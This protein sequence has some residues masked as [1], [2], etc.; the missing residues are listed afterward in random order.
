MSSGL[1]KYDRGFVLLRVLKKEKRKKKSNTSI[2]LHAILLLPLIV[3]PLQAAEQPEKLPQNDRSQQPPSL[4]RGQ[5]TTIGAWVP[6]F[7]QKFYL[8]IIMP[9]EKKNCFQDVPRAHGAEAHLAS[10]GAPGSG[11]DVALSCSVLVISAKNL[12][13]NLPSWPTLK[14]PTSII[15]SALI[16]TPL[17]YPKQ[18]FQQESLSNI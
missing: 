6:P 15:H 16:F 12:T 8:T 1:C 10:Y 11:H 3:S 13:S 4:Y 17:T 18:S 9:T 7:H 5:T 2:Q 14:E